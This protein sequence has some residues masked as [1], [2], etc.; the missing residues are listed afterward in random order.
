MDEIAVA[1]LVGAWIEIGNP[2]T[3]VAREITVAPLAGAWIEIV[4]HLRKH[5]FPSGRSPCG[6]VDRVDLRMK[7][8]ISDYKSMVWRIQPIYYVLFGHGDK[9]L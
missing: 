2:A 5:P 3:L 4:Q 7:S 9:I 1:P 6:S 8:F